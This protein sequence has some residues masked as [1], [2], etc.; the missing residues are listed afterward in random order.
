MDINLRDGWLSYSA[1]ALQL[2]KDCEVDYLSRLCRNLE[3]RKNEKDMK[4]GSSCL[5]ADAFIILT[6]QGVVLTSGDA[7]LTQ[8]E[9]RY[10]QGLSRQLIKRKR[11]ENLPDDE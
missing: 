11:R 4:S 5:G 8:E 2:M 10:L 9:D 3:K 6:K 7:R 1:D